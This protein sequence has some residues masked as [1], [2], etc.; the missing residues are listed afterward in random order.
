MEGKT[1]AG[2]VVLYQ[3]SLHQQGWWVQASFF[4]VLTQYTDGVGNIC[5]GNISNVTYET[6]ETLSTI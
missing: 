4:Q 6:C 2:Q 3:C 1:G 5:P